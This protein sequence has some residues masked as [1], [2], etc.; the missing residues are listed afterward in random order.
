M[1][2]G[3]QF[4]GNSGGRLGFRGR[5]AA[6]PGFR[7]GSLSCL[8]GYA[9]APL[10]LLGLGLIWVGALAG[11]GSPAF[12]QFATTPRDSLISDANCGQAEEAVS[13][14]A[15]GSGYTVLIESDGVVLRL[16]RAG[17]GPGRGFR[18]GHR[19][20]GGSGW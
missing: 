20:A 3:R 8:G 15:R 19:R 6:R 1:A 14:L 9:Q 7:S 11:A 12:G 16:G 5:V 18:P 17:P 13:F 10:S 2:F 4:K